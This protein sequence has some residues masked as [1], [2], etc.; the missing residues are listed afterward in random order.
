[1]FFLEFDNYF[2]K[3]SLT[4]LFILK[5]F[6]FT[7]SKEDQYFEKIYF[8]EKEN[9]LVIKFKNNKDKISLPAKF[10]SIFL[11]L[12]KNLQNLFINID[13]LSYYPI[14]QSIV[15]ADKEII[16]GAIHNTIFG[17]LLLHKDSGIDKIRLYQM[18]WPSDKDIAINK[19]D[20]HLTNLKSKLIQN[21]NL[22]LTLSTINGS[23]KLITK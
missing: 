22:N 6:Q 13:N 10:D 8:H 23:I 19:L 16:L 1:M 12:L 9:Y 21:A 7:L 11:L 20:T 17:N 15:F 5:N 14:K 3:N 18:I 2:L 4:K